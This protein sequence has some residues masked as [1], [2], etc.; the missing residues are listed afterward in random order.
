MRATA[1]PER[2]GATPARRGPPGWLIGVVVVVI[3]LAVAAF[4]YFR[5][6]KAAP[7]GAA[8]VATPAAS[9]P[10]VGSAPTLATAQPG[11]ASAPA[12]VPPAAPA[13][14]E[15]AAPAAQPAAP[16]PQPAEQPA[17]AS[18]PTATAPAE[19]APAPV[20][21]TLQVAAGLVR[22]GERAYAQGDYE[23]AYRHARS[24]LDVHP[25]YAPAERLMRRAEQ[26][27]Q[28]VAAQQAQAQSQAAAAAA[29]RDQAAAAAAAP[30]KPTPDEIYNQRAHSECARGLFGKSCRHKVRV[31][32]C[33]GVSP[34]A[35]GATVCKGQDD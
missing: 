7:Q 22:K 3:V 5:F 19:V 1:R 16:A 14:S 13:A 29:A 28:Q 11:A 10:A 20:D 18:A 26:T 23:Q 9:A 30:P 33:Q 12:A 15:P 21:Q 31:A 17:V 32:V 25:G 4:A 27:Q 8:V 34:D 24:A 6:F 2:S 35:P